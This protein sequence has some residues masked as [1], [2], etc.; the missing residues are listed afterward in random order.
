MRNKFVDGGPIT[1]RV[2]FYRLDLVVGTKPHNRKLKY[3]KNAGS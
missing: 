1:F 3:N 2:N